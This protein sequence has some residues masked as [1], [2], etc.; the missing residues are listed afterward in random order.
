MQLLVPA[1]AGLV[2]LAVVL[3]LVLTPAGN[4]ARLLPLALLA[5]D[6]KV[7]QSGEGGSVDGLQKAAVLLVILVLALRQGVVLEP[8]RL[9]LPAVLAVSAVLSLLPIHDGL[10]RSSPDVAVRAFLGYV[11]PWT[12]LL[13]R[14]RR[15]QVRA[16]LRFAMVLPILTIPLGIVMHVAGI[17]NMLSYLDGTPRLQGS[18]IPAHLAMLAVVG[19]LAAA[20]ATVTDPASERMAAW[21]M[22]LNLLLCVATFTRV[23]ILAAAIVLL[24][25][26]AWCLSRE[27]RLRPRA[28]AATA[29]SVGFLVLGGLVALPALLAR[30]SG[31]SYE[32]SFN[33]SGREQAWPFYLSLGDASPLIGRGLGFS[34]VAQETLKPIGVQTLEAPHNEYIHLYV[35]GGVVLLALFLLGLALVLAR[36]A[37]VG[38]RAGLVVGAFGLALAVYAVTDNPFSTPQFSVP[39]AIVLAALLVLRQ[40]RREDPAAAASAALEDAVLP[41]DPHHGQPVPQRDRRTEEQEAGDHHGERRPVWSARG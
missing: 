16:M 41:G 2:Y 12:V 23:G 4:Q 37:E 13:V 27:G 7:F 10:L 24:G 33:T 20:V 26:I 36:A 5:V 19:V 25:L 11:L 9:V 17:W 35:D 31:N 8:L 32:G 30:S 21:T 28:R 29:W 6:P 18:S 14:W 34:S 1:L 22:R 15:D 38:H 39:L 40:E 3:V